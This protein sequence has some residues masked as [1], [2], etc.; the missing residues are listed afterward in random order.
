M[1]VRKA[2]TARDRLVLLGTSRGLDL[3]PLGVRGRH[4]ALL[5]GDG[6][7]ASR[8][9]QQARKVM[10]WRDQRRNC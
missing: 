9:V 6:G 8:G 5:P 10:W 2:L 3:S 1:N 4:P 7:L